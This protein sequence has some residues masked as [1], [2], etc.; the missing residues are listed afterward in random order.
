VASLTDQTDAPPLEALLSLASRFPSPTNAQA[1]AAL[2]SFSQSDA[3]SMIRVGLREDVAR[4]FLLPDGVLPRMRL[5]AWGW[6]KKGDKFKSPSDA[7]WWRSRYQFPLW[8]PLETYLQQASASGNEPPAVVWDDDL[9]AGDQAELSR[10]LPQVVQGDLPPV[11]E[12][13]C[14]KWLIPPGRGMLPI[15]NPA[16][17]DPQ[18]VR[19]EIDKVHR[20][21]GTDYSWVVWVILGILMLDRRK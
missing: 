12:A 18:P 6:T 4:S 10:S 9:A 14:P 2:D 11:F 13:P 7:A 5:L 3:D 17:V 15:I 8:A 1:V 20:R 19:D 16:C 21:G